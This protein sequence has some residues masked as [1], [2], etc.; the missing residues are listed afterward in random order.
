M[1]D[2]TLAT[3]AEETMGVPASLIAEVLASPA[4]ASSAA[5]PSA[6]LGRYIAASERVWRYVDGWRP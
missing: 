5:D 4:S 1:S 2:E 6:L 3:A